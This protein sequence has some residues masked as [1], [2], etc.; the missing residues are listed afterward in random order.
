M[1]LPPSGVT[2]KVSSMPTMPDARDALLR[3]E[4]QH[5]ALCQRLVK[6]LGQHRQ[7]V[8][9]QADPVAEEVRPPVAEAHEVLKEF[10]VQAV[11]DAGVDLRGDRSRFDQ[12]GQLVLDLHAPPVER[13]ITS[14]GSGRPNM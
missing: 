5:H 8:D 1:L 4:G 6:S 12:R 10:R 9:L 3:L 14:S 11:H 7:L 13:A 2:T